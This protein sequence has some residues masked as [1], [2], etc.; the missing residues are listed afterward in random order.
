MTPEEALTASAEIKCGYRGISQTSKPVS[1]AIPGPAAGAGFSIALAADFRVATKRDYRLS[2]STI[3]ASGDE[4]RGLARLIGEAKAKE[5]MLSPRVSA[6][7][8]LGLGS[9][10]E[11]SLMPL[12]TQWHSATNL[13]RS[14]I[15]MRMRRKISSVHSRQ[16]SRPHSTPKAAMVKQW[17]PPIIAGSCSI[18]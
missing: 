9:S 10:I 8:A 15:A 13:A 4:V 11:C 16:M 17:R 5:F 1:A 2:F 7:E 14:P 18:L 12:M 3:G 6:S